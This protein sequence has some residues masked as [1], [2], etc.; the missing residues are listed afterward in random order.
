[1]KPHSSPA[2]PLAI[3]IFSILNLSAWS[4]DI[5]WFSDDHEWYYR[6][7]CMNDPACGYVHYQV[8]G[9]TMLAGQTGRVL[10]KID[11]QE[12]QAPL[13]DPLIL[14]Q[15]N[16]TVFRYSPEA[17][18]WHMLYDMAATPGDV[19]NIQDDE[20]YLGYG[21]IE[22][23]DLLFRVVVDS[24]GTMMVNQELRRTVYTSAWTDGNT[25]SNFHFG[26]SSAIIEGIGPV[27]QGRG[28]EGQPTAEIIISLPA[29]FHCFL[30]DDG[31][32][33]GAANSPCFTLTTNTNDLAQADFRVYP[34]PARSGFSIASSQGE[35]LLQSVQLIDAQGRTVR[36]WG[37]G[38]VIQASQQTFDVSG[39]P[40]GIYLLQLASDRGLHTHKL[41]LE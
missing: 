31:L 7:D 32:V 12:A 26:Y 24:V 15:A 37:V 6:V 22:S 27:D 23:D 18:R 5:P 30:N 11:L 1:M 28:L 38:D 13:I 9:D 16:D 39:L 17:E 25:V 20:E 36:T 14:R 41:I 29:G 3:L 19:W 34:N 2:K 40:A 10:Q 4:Q 33:Y 21:L 8:I 35:P